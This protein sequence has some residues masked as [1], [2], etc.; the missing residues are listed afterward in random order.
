MSGQMSRAPAGAVRTGAIL[1]VIRS[2]DPREGGPVEGIRQMIGPYA[3][4]GWRIDV[5]CLD[6]PAAPWLAAFPAKV[7]ALGPAKGGYGLRWDAIGAVR[8]LAKNYDAVIANGIWEFSGPLTMLALAGTDTPYYVFSHG[9]LDP[10]FKHQ[11]P[12]KHMKKWLYWPWSVYWLLRRAKAVLF[13][14]EEERILA[15]QSFWLYRCNE[16]VVGYGASRPS[17][18]AEAQRSAFQA[19]YPATV[20]TR[21]LLFLGRIHRKKGCDLLIEAYAKVIGDDPDWRLIMAG[22]DATGWRPELEAL[23][24]RLDVADRIVWTGP[25]GGDLKWGAFHAADAFVLPSHQENFG[26]AV[27]EAAACSLPV[28]VS[29]KV[30][31]WR[32]IVQWNGG[33]VERDDLAGTISLLNRWKTMTPTDVE[34]MRLAALACFN[35]NFDMQVSAARMIDLLS[36]DPAP[37]AGQVTA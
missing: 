8:K 37:S 6:D 28:L 2:L 36:A 22:P 27:A 9:M 19:A 23:A 30:N 14:T 3:A 32:E 1:H 26:V 20:G 11:Y 33:L 13:T 16:V 7:Y 29:D 25:L 5:V 31:I 35:V 34:A 10:W 4:I 12:L 24:K 21:N 18:D 17:G 15:R